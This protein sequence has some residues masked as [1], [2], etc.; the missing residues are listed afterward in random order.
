MLY[1][2]INPRNTEKTR[3][4]TLLKFSIEKHYLRMTGKKYKAYYMA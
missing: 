4:K 2:E 1:K 3:L